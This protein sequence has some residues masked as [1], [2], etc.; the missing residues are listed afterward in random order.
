MKKYILPLALA[1][2][3]NMTVAAAYNDDDKNVLLITG[4]LTNCGADSTR[5]YE[6]DGIGY[7]LIAQA[8]LEHN[9][10]G[11]NTFS[12]KVPKKLQR[13]VYFIGSDRNNV[14]TLV[15]G[16]EK[17]YTETAI[18]ITGDC[19][20]WKT[21]TVVGAPDNALLDMAMQQLAQLNNAAGQAVMNFR[22]ANGDA[23]Q[24]LKA[25]EQLRAIDI[26]KLALLDSVG[27][28]SPFV[29]A[30]VTLRT[31]IS[32]YYDKKTYA[33]EL[34]YFGNEYFNYNDFKN[35]AYFE[36]MPLLS[37]AYREYTQTLGMVG[38]PPEV[39]R[40]FIDKALGKIPENSR[41]YKAALTGVMQ[42]YID[43]DATNFV[44]Y[45]EQW[46]TKYGKE[47]GE[48][49]PGLKQRIAAVQSQVLGGVAPDIK[50]GTPEGGEYAL[51]QLR[52][53]VVLIDFWASWCGPCQ[54]QLTHTKKLAEKYTEKGVV[55]IYISMDSDAEAWKYA[56][57]EKN[58]SGIHANDKTIIPLNFLIQGLPN[59]FIVGKNGKIAQNSMLRS[60]INDEKMIDYLL[61][62]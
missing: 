41:A 2:L 23:A 3:A 55:F 45:A 59:C 29:K 20:Q 42:A 25:T 10:D 49:T 37:D 22:N 53:K 52:G 6:Y 24:T 34:Q 21:A 44:H 11:S 56:L 58:L 33:D 54:A 27:K 16:T 12:L 32:W 15:I 28:V 60:K 1:F 48:H 47:S 31:Y 35:I 4:S 50:L 26:Q 5:L 18:R 40:G 43:K 8:L 61:K 19:A 30:A 62:M 38:M 7:H 51:S 46:L 36:K 57:K 39:Q 9:A 17:G 13:G 14:R